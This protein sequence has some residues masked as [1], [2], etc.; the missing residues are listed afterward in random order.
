MMWGPLISVLA[1]RHG[2]QQSSGDSASFSPAPVMNGGRSRGATKRENIPKL[3][4]HLSMVISRSKVVGNNRDSSV[5]GGGSRGESACVH[6]SRF[7]TKRMHVCGLLALRMLTMG[8]ARVVEVL[9]A[10]AACGTARRR[11]SSSSERRWLE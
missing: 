3:L 10:A 5:S 8:Q 7:R 2:Q 6:G 9:V 1:R 11:C 4:V